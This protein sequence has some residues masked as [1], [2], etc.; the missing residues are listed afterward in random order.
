MHRDLLREIADEAI[1]WL[2]TMS[3]IGLATI[4]R[5][6][7]RPEQASGWIEQAWAISRSRDAPMIQA[8]VLVGRGYTAD[9]LGQYEQAI[10]HQRH[11]LAIALAH[12]TPRGVANSMEGMAGALAI[13]PDPRL[14]ASAA[15]LL[16][17][18]DAVRRRSGGAMPP[19][20]RF[21]VD[22]AER[23]GRRSMGDQAFEVAFADGA[24]GEL[25]MV[26]DEVSALL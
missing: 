18:A 6:T 23:R 13:A 2:R 17:A 8:L 22:R 19:A 1:P 10:D 3:L 24:G 7:H 11:G 5:R 21:D 26:L 12:S 14:H 25:Q 4:A 9:L 15:R 16:G 20:E